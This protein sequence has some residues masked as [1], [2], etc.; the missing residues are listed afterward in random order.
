MNDSFRKQ[1]RLTKAKN[2]YVLKQQ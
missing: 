2:V 1:Y